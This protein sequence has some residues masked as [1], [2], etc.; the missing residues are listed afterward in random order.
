MVNG[1]LEAKVHEALDNAY[2]N[3]YVGFLRDSSHKEIA[4]DLVDRN[5]ALENEEWPSLMPHIRSWLARN[6]G[7][8]G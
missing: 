2:S 8:L 3:G 1:D 7:S 4:I 6:K 5:A